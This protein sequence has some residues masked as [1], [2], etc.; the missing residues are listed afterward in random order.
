M[1]STLRE[2]LDVFLR[3][4]SKPR[5]WV[6]FLGIIILFAITGPFDTFANLTLLM[7]FVYWSVTMIGSWLIAMI[8]V[9][10]A[11][12]I[13]IKRFD[14]P[15]VLT[16]VSSILAA[17]PITAFL[18]WVIGWFFGATANIGFWS[19]LPFATVM[20]V[21]FCII[22]YFVLPDGFSA[23]NQSDDENPL[24]AR[25]PVGIR[26]PIKHMTMQDHYMQVTT[27]RG[28]ELI[29]MRMGDAVGMMPQ[30][31]GM[32]VHRSHWVGLKF[33]ANTSRENGQAVIIMDD[34]ATYPVSRTYAKS[35]REAGVL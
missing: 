31:E 21:V 35:V 26:G 32:Q 33:I 30:G 25:L 16:L 17:W 6:V 23:V 34:G 11:I 20:A 2:I 22:I 29:L 8:F 27:T 13:F 15:L 1:Q 14:Y 3:S 10:T 19:L 24:L 7:R 28:K 18:I 4:T 12:G 9:S 5:F